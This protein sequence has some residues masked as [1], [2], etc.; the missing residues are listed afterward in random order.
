VLAT[1]K[2]LIGNGEDTYVKSAEAADHSSYLRLGLT[3]AAIHI[4]ADEAT[5]L[6]TD[7]DLYLSLRNAGKDAINFNHIREWGWQAGV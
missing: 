6:T 2:F 4:A 1:L 3:D 5:V 7:L